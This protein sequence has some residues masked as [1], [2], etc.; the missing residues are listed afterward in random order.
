VGERQKA[1]GM[2]RHKIEDALAQ[3][4]DALVV[5]CPS[6][7]QQFDL[8]QAAVLRETGGEGLPV[9]YLTEFV[10]MAMGLNVDELGLDMHRIDTAPFLEKWN[11]KLEQ[12][13]TLMQSF[14]I[15]ELQICAGCKACDADC[16]VCGV[17]EQFVPS[18]LINQLL[19]EGVDAVLEGADIWQCV[20]CL[21]CYEK[22]HSRIGMASVFEK[23]KRLA[24]EQG[25]A[26]A[27]AVSSYKAFMADG[28][29]GTGRASARQKLGLPDLPE[30]GAAELKTILSSPKEDE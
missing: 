26:P 7:F 24:Q 14:S 28:V 17:H 2:C 5:S 23:L 29:L 10:A 18:R 25:K 30:N 21:T 22:C 13:A 16:P 12:R 20:D 4:A 3:G 9:F 8:N 27:A 11:R 19:T 6:C 15:A 1:L